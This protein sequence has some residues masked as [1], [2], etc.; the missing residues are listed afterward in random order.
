[1]RMD[2]K[3]LDIYDGGWQQMRGRMSESKTVV[4][5]VELWEGNGKWWEAGYRQ[6]ETEGWLED[7]R[8]QRSD[9]G[10]GQ[11]SNNGCVMMGRPKLI[12]CNS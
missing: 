11:V 12:K 8:W 7:A 6:S 10:D 9:H 3:R 5:Q 1:M 2:K 4:R